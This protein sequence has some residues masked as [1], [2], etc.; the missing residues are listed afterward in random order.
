MCP[1][2]VKCTLKSGKDKREKSIF[3]ATVAK[4]FVFLSFLFLPLTFF[5]WLTLKISLLS[6]FYVARLLRITTFSVTSICIKCR[7]AECPIFIVMLNV[8]MPSVM[9]P[10]LWQTAKCHSA[11]WQLSKNIAENWQQCLWHIWRW[12]RHEQLWRHKNASPIS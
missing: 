9:G 6:W 4:A 1:T 5:V 2:F 7:Y 10:M 3:I 12:W 11:K 8:I